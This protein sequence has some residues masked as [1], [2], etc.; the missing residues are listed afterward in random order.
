MKRSVLLVAVLSFLALTP[1][2]HADKPCP[3]PPVSGPVTCQPPPTGPVLPPVG[4]PG[5]L[6]PPVTPLAA[7]TMTNGPQSSPDITQA[8]GMNDVSCSN[9]SGASAQVVLNCQADGKAASAF[10]PGNYGTDVND[11]VSASG[12]I[13]DPGNSFAALLQ[14]IMS[15]FWQLFATIVSGILVVL[16]AAFSYDLF[17]SGLNALSPALATAESGFFVP[18]LGL[19][20]LVGGMVTLWYL[21]QDNWGRMLSHLATMIAMAVVAI[22]IMLNVGG[23]LS[24]ADTLANGVAVSA[25]GAFSG[26]SAGAPAFANSEPAIWR[27]AVELPWA[28]AEFGSTTWAMQPPDAAMAQTRGQVIA[29]LHAPLQ[30]YPSWV[31]IVDQKAF[32][33]AWVLAVA[34]WT[35]RLNA[36]KTNGELFLA[37]ETNSAQRTLGGT[38]PSF[39]TTLG[40][41]HPDLLGISQEGGVPDH[42]VTLILGG[43]AGLG[44]I[45]VVGELALVIVFSSFA[46]VVSLLML[47]LVALTVGTPAGQRAC[48]KWLTFLMGAFFIRVVCAA[49]LGALLV[50]SSVLFS[51]IGSIGFFFGWLT[52]ATFWWGCWKSRHLL[53]RLMGIQGSPMSYAGGHARRVM[54]RRTPRVRVS[55]QSQPSPQPPPSPPPGP[56]VR[57]APRPTPPTP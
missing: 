47:P 26:Q 46:V 27:N 53:L 52:V 23:M 55:G 48:L 39:A 45:L 50:A 24:W 35:A 29:S 41:E 14:N 11:S 42:L 21:A 1:V 49:V 34:A 30:Q 10:P 18:L 5:G 43:I 37:F 33:A 6:Q 36:A 17:S 20:L 38:G 16:S 15:W 9:L 56:S 13:T 12:T 4:G 40:G 31:P 57:P 19:A 32:N 28:A 2:A 22:G 8:L 54:P 44:F 51:V 3:P 7:P 25:I